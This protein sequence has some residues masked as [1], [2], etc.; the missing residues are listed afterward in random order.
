MGLIAVVGNTGNPVSP[1]AATGV[2]GHAE[3]P[4]A[5][6][7]YPLFFYSLRSLGL[8]RSQ[9]LLFQGQEAIGQHDQASM[10]VEPQP[11][12][13]FIVVQAQL[14]L[15]LLIPLFHRPATLPQP[16]CP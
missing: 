10:M 9:T 5:S 14:F 15:H 11:E 7:R 8:L 16:H 2:A 12:A 3:P 13:T 4:A 6:G 1:V